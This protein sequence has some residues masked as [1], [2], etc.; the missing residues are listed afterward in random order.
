MAAQESVSEPMETLVRK[1]NEL[2]YGL[3][4]ASERERTTQWYLEREELMNSL[5]TEIE[6]LRRGGRRR[7]AQVRQPGGHPPDTGTV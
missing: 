6:R 3:A 7:R 5:T 2:A 4:R 1:R